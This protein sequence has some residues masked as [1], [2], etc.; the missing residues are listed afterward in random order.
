MIKVPFV[1]WA[2]RVLKKGFWLLGFLPQIID[3]IFAFIPADYI[4]PPVKSFIDSGGSWNLT[5]TLLALGLIISS[6]IVYKEVEKEKQDVQIQLE[7]IKNSEPKI[8]VGLRNDSGELGVKLVVE[9]QSIPPR[10]DFEKEV[11]IERQQLLSRASPKQPNTNFDNIPDIL[12]LINSSM[13]DEPNPKY[14]EEVEEYLIEYHKY[15]VSKWEININRAFSFYPMAINEGGTTASDVRIEFVMPHEFAKPCKHQAFDRSDI[16]DEFRP[17]LVHKP[18]E[19][20][21]SKRTLDS[22]ISS[23]EYL[24]P[25]MTESPQANQ[26]PSNGPYY[27]EKGGVWIISYTKQKLVPHYLENDFDLFWVWAGNIDKPT[28]WKI[29]VRIYSS[30][31]REPQNGEIDLEFVFDDG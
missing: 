17:F 5:L 8:T 30:E 7:E 29:Q 24:I 1:K 20:Q 23:S 14:Q 22:I 18:Y 4:P 27:E 21:P 12:K 26:I 2:I 3:Y 10:P 25:A 15:L 31:I 6:Y 19:P 11:S 9:L 13:L 16:D 28:T